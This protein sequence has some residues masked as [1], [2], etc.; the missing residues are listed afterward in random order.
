MQVR[1][2]IKKLFLAV[3]DLL[4][5]R[6]RLSLFYVS[7]CQWSAL[8]PSVVL[9]E[10]YHGV[11]FFGN[12]YYLAKHLLALEC[13]RHL[14]LVIVCPKK[15]EARLKSEFGD[16]ISFCRVNSVLYCFHLATASFLV[17]DVTFPVFFAR[18]EGQKYLNTWH[19]TPLKTLGR[20]CTKDTFAL[21]S[22]PQRNLLHATHLLA[23]NSHT[24]QVLL[25][26]YM[27][28]K[29]W[30]GY[31]YCCGYPRNDAFFEAD[32]GAD[33]ND[34][35][36][37]NAV[38]MPTWRGTLATVTEASRQQ[39]ANLKLLFDQLDNLLPA[40]TMLWVRLHPMVRSCIDLQGYIQLRPFPETV[41]P[42]RFLADC[43]VLVTDYSSVL[44]DFAVTRKPILLYTP[45]AAAYQNERDYC[46]DL[47]SLPFEQLKTPQALAQR[48]AA[49]RQVPPPVTAAYNAFIDRFCPYD[50]GNSCE[51]LA[52]SFF[53]EED[54]LEVRKVVPDSSKKSVL[55]FVGAFYRNGITS[56]VKSLIDAI[57]K[58]RFNLF[59]WI[60][61]RA[62]QSNA[63][64]Y[65]SK[66]DSRVN[67][68]PTQNWLALSV[69]DALRFLLRDLSGRL[70]RPGDAFDQKIWNRE[71]SRMFAD[72]DFDVMVNFS[73]YERR[74]ALLQMA[75]PCRR[76]V[77]FVHNDMALELSSKQVDSRMLRMLYQISD[78][79]ATVR[80]GVERA[81]CE[82]YYDFS[83]KVIFVP[84]T[85]P[86]NC[87][88]LSTQPLFVAFSDEVEPAYAALVEDRVGKPD[89]Y[90]FINLAR[91][92]PEKGQLRLITA[93]ERVW[94]GNPAVELYIVGGYGVSYEGVCAAAK[95]SPANESIFVFKGS[96]NIFPLLS[97]MNA[98][99]FSSF[100][101]G[102]GLVLYEAFALGLSVVSTDIP[103]PSELLRQGYGLVVD[104]SID[105][106][107]FGMQSAMQGE[108]PQRPY[109]FDAHNQ[110]ALA[111]F[112][113]ALGEPKQGD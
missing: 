7:F 16:L 3:L 38:F 59:M 29:L 84:N 24:E 52:R 111:Q 50:K 64:D 6:R 102:I 5:R 12:P 92:S 10:S 40:N 4:S 25:Q 37:I 76:K 113:K 17:N 57:D 8:R 98:L 110:F 48:L 2:I 39:L 81:Y 72:V 1:L 22:N 23:P 58:D 20:K 9:L 86:T 75:S 70:W 89:Q 101:E 35:N 26:D 69:G 43:D 42:Y 47:H 32:L 95:S 63:G 99:V 11:D 108:V 27:I 93:F 67:Y 13:Y 100:Y 68:I 79:V 56:S 94:A 74:V 96:D 36:T 45:D 62:A 80:E 104:N 97:K 54:L 88:Q 19:G 78:V 106:L 87:R 33:H 28:E 41:E 73:G 82:Q 103:G 51:L 65:F 90:R 49:I 66:L 21:L 109:D 105:G 55:L 91:F 61:Q 53:L 85:L 71:W 46:L 14:H 77:A 15:S 30:R 34:N 44:F 107:V 31:V 18:R 83:D 60:D 112:Y